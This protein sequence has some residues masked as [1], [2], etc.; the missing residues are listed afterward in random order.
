VEK[1]MAK[2]EEVIKFS[3]RLGAEK[4]QKS[5]EVAERYGMSMNALI[6]YVMGQYLDTVY[7]YKDETVKKMAIEL[8]KN[9]L[10]EQRQNEK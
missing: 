2:K 10:E 7:D 3:L 1:K 4:Y 5:A 6:N 8:A 9:I